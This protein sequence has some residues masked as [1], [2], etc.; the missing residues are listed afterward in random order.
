MKKILF[1]LVLFVA[2]PAI[3]AV[4]TVTPPTIYT[5][6]TAIPAAKT[7]TMTYTP[8]WGPVDV[9]Q[10]TWPNVGSTGAPGATTLNAPDPPPGSTYWY[11]V[12]VTLDGQ[13]S[14]KGVAASKAVPFRVPGLPGVAVN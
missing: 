3:A 4:I 7:P 5:D 13:T 11:T 2:A 10:G 14:G 6:D 8:M 9:G 12:T 1:L